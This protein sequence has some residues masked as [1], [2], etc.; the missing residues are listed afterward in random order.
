VSTTSSGS[1]WTRPAPGTRKPRFTREQIAEIA[2]KI[3]D[4]EGFDALS[5]RR[6]ADELG[7]GTMTLY[8]YV[9]TK[10]D[11]IALMDDALMA[12][13]LVPPDLLRG[14]WMAAMSAIARASYRVFARHPWAF[15][16]LSGARFGPNT[17][18]HIEQSL[19]AIARAPFDPQGKLDAI[20][21]VDDY[22]FGH[23][24][25]GAEL[26]RHQELA[27]DAPSDELVA[28][29]RALLATGEYPQ[30]EAMVGD[31]IAGAWSRIAK[32]MVAEHRFKRGLVALLEGLRR[33]LTRA[34]S[35]SR[36]RGRPQRGRSSRRR[37]RRHDQPTQ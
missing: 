8:H 17:M 9:R 5:M 6:I 31:D 27:G 7:A 12:D 36:G 19:T 16:A 1:I 37:G 24:H 29:T 10:E 11:L 32:Q 2:V 20:G 35:R 34:R 4:R 28:F 21:I 22:V 26:L 23:I 15:S 3:A 25:R 13:V 14:D 33:T 30:L 18:R